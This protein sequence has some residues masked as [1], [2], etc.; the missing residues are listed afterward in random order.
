MKILII[1]KKNLMNAI[2][3]IGSL[4]LLVT[5]TYFIL[6]NFKSKQTISPINISED[7]QYDLT[8]DGK[9]DILQRL[10]SQNRIDFNI[11][12]SNDNYYLQIVLINFIA[13]QLNSCYNLLINLL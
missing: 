2:F 6:N 9:K 7:T 11:N 1:K 10:N 5:L 4:I 13:I 12:H 8:G 3:Y